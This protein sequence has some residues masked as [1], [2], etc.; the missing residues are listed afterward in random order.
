ML[1]KWA[2]GT[3]L[4]GGGEGYLSGKLEEF[5]MMLVDGLLTSEEDR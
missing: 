3:V 4:H 1:W 5:K 2:S